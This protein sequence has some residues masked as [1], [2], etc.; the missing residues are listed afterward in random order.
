LVGLFVGTNDLTNVVKDITQNH[1]AVPKQL[2]I[3]GKVIPLG[4]GHKGTRD[5]RKKWGGFIKKGCTA[6]SIIKTLY[7]LK[8]VSEFMFHSTK[9][10]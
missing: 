5:F 8:H 2:D 4:I 9:S 3:N 7:L 1:N 10:C 6:E